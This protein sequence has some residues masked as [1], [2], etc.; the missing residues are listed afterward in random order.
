MNEDAINK[1]VQPLINIQAQQEGIVIKAIAERLS[2]MGEI[3]PSDVAKLEQLLRTGN[4]AQKIN[5][6]LSRLSGKSVQEIKSIIKEVA[7]DSYEQAKPF[8]DYRHKSFIP[9]DKNIQLQRTIKAIEVVSLGEYRR[10]SSTAAFMIRS[11]SNP[12]ILIPTKLSKTYNA[13]I[14]YA[15]QFIVNGLG[16]Y[17][18]MIGQTIQMLTNS[19]MQTVEY[20]QPNGKKRYVRMDTAIRRN[21]LDT[22]RH[23]QQEVQN[24]VGKEFGADGVEL[25]VHAFSAPDHEPFQG[26]QFT[27]EEF[28]KLQSGE[29]FKDVNGVSFAGVDRPIG[30]WNCRHFAWNIIIGHAT[31]NYTPE[32]LEAMKQKNAK[33]IKVKDK[34]GNLV[35]RS[36]YWCTQRQ[37]QYEVDLRR[38]GEQRNAFK[39]AGNDEQYKNIDRKYKAKLQEY[40]AFSNKCGLRLKPQNFRVYN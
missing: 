32:Q 26:H 8:Y 40:K 5:K 14:D 24:E 22:V 35:N 9:Y 30:M 20:A 21:I 37:R 13:A 25:S 3:I 28:D 31:P 15:V 17:D 6:E 29:P 11:V 34:N 23:V 19:G 12:N 7:A 10:L 16:N 2:D 18:Q 36:M 39:Q 27:M 38:L 33:G 1:L 4:D